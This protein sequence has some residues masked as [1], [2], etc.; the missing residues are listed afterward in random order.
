MSWQKRIMGAD[1]RSVG[2]D[3]DPRFSF[4]NERTFLAW[5]RTGLALISVGLA[6]TQ[7]LPPFDFTGGRKVIG[8]PLI[9][10][11]AAVSYLSLRE[12]AAN[13][14]AMR[15]GEPLPRTHLVIIISVVIAI[16]GVIAL[17]VAATSGA[18]P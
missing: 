14:T 10:L 7:L 18:L 4:A 8:L 15:R 3:P 9:A 12:W 16:I 13:E 5:N 6:V 1:P 2:K 11:G 17:V